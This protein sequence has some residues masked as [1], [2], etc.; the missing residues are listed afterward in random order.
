MVQINREAES[1]VVARHTEVVTGD[2]MIDASAKKQVRRREH[3]PT[4]RK[5]TRGENQRDNPRKAKEKSR[6]VET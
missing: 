6:G 3:K 5:K 2:P 1:S 4:S